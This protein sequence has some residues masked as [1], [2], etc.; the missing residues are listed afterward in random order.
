M[1]F[2]KL[3]GSVSNILTTFSLDS[4]ISCANMAANTGDLKE[5]EDERNLFIFLVKV[6]LLEQRRQN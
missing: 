4:L 5:V 6:P 2:L 3:V 1:K